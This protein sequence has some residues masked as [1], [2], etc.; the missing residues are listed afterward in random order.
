MGTTQRL[1]PPPTLCNVNPQIKAGAHQR[2]RNEK[3]VFFAEHG[4]FL[5]HL[6]L[7]IDLCLQIEAML[8]S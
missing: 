3:A 6:S 7:T 5:Q 4:M 8:I 1:P 2:Q